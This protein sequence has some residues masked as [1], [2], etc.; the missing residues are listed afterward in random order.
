MRIFAVTGTTDGVCRRYDAII[1]T[2]EQLA[3]MVLFTIRL[4]LRCR[5]ICYVDAAMSKGSYQMECDAF[6]PDPHVIDLNTILVDCDEAAAM[7]IPDKERTWVV[8]SFLR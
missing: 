8:L 1:Q 3:N 5:V 7:T 2:Y 4:E 6:E